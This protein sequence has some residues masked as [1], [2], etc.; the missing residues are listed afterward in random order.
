MDTW[1]TVRTVGVNQIRLATA[2]VCL[3]MFAMF[4]I[5]GS[6]AGLSVVPMYGA[7]GAVECR[8]PEH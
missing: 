3:T 1:Q 2:A 7:S 5:C 6:L 4:F 8:D